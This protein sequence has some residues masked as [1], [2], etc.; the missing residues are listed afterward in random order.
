[1]AK[2]GQKKLLLFASNPGSDL[3]A[4]AREIESKHSDRYE[5]RVIEGCDMA[6]FT[7]RQLEANGEPPAAIIT[8]YRTAG[9]KTGPELASDIK[10]RNKKL[11]VVLYTNQHAIKALGERHGMPVLF[12]RA[13]KEIED[14]ERL[15]KLVEAPGKSRTK[16][17]KR[18]GRGGGRERGG[19]ED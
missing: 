13:G 18:G 10:V 4:I 11:P 16:G 2:P 1:M 5:V 3:G 6:Y 19:D 8:D 15:I 14:A 9:T 7:F 17:S 12:A